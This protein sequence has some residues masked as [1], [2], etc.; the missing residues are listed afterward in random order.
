MQFKKRDKGIPILSKKDLEGYA[1]E[2][3]EGYNKGLLQKA[4]PTPIEDILEMHLALEMDYQKLEVDKSILGLTCFA[5]GYLGVYN[6]KSGLETIFVKKNTV[7]V[8]NELAEDKSM[9][10]RYRFT[11]SHEASHWLLHR[12][13]FEKDENQICMFD[14]SEAK[15]I[16]CLNRNIENI[17]LYYDF[18]TDGEWIEWQADYLGG[19]ILMPS[20]SMY[21]AF[22][23]LLEKLSIHQYYIFV[24]NQSCNIKNYRTVVN[25]LSYKFNVS[26]KA[27]QVRLDKLGL[28]KR[29]NGQFSFL[30]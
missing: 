19:A 1:I 3:L 7:I 23:E 24:D 14:N 10:G 22:T 13:M 11:C 29:D 17:F 20:P 15:V 6:E 8:D 30:S 28:I 18:K 4:Q 9:E 25:E 12:H 16:K 5:D 27:V 26:K 21:Q 2:F